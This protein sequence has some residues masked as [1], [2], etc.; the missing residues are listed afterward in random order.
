MRRSLR[1]AVLALV[2]LVLLADLLIV[3]PSLASLAGWIT[4]L[5]VLLVAA[6]AVGGALA[7]IAR[8]TGRLAS[9]EDRIGGAA[10]LIGLGL[11]LI[12]GLAPGSG[13]PDGPAVRWVVAALLAPLVA[14][15]FALLFPLLLAAARR[16]LRLR[17]RETAVM[18]VAAA[19][20]LIL[21]LPVR[22]PGGEGLGAVS[23]WVRAVPVAA[24]FR[25]M[26]IGV[27]VMAAVTAAR[28][29]FGTE[30][31]DE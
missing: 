27:A 13:G 17:G 28:V 1:S 11:V 20:V 30:A 15:V 31:A 14:S 3:N 5:V 19:A 26:L 29:L 12:P 8:H 10:V 16:G 23:E 22:G 9:G 4:Q 2:G 18:L 7:L 25:G 24:V 6:V 21:L